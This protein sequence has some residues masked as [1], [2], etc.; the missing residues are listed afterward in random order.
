MGQATQIWGIPPSETGYYAVMH[1][2]NA[3]VFK[4]QTETH[5]VE[6]FSYYASFWAKTNYP[7]ALGVEVADIVSEVRKKLGIEYGVI[8]WGV[9]RD[10]PA[11][12]A[13]IQRGDYL[14]SING[15]PIISRL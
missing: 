11:A 5:E 15:E 14:I 7:P 6:V 4:N 3:V 13:Q 9:F 8:A 1:G 2:A 10:S 12:K